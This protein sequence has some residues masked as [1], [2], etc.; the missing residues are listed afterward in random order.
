MGRHLA[1]SSHD[2]TWKLWDLET[3]KLLYAQTGHVAAVYG[4][5]FQRDGSLLASGDLNGIAMAWDLRSG[6]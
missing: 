5:D 1:S 3:Q 6:R 4:I 2:K